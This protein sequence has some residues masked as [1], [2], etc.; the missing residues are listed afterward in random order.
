MREGLRG[1]SE[2]LGNEKG[3]GGGGVDTTASPR[4]ALIHV[5]QLVEKAAGMYEKRWAT[6]RLTRPSALS[7]HATDDRMTTDRMKGRTRWALHDHCDLST[8][9]EMEDHREEPTTYRLPRICIHVP[10]APESTLRRDRY[11][12]LR[13]L[14]AATHRNASTTSA[15]FRSFIDLFA[16]RSSKGLSGPMTKAQRGTRRTTCVIFVLVTPLTQPFPFT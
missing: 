1:S 4:C 3:L 14:P 9:E 12:P 10:P 11:M 8:H 7:D 2:S 16:A 6:G 15:T 13:L 5:R